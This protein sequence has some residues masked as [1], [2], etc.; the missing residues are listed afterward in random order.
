MTKWFGCFETQSVRIEQDFRVGGDYKIKINHSENI[1]V[2]MSGSFLEIVPNEKLV[3]SWNSD[4]VEYPAHNTLVTV[5]FFDK[6]A[7][8]EI[9]LK[10]SKFDRPVSVQGHS[11]GWGG[12]LDKFESLFA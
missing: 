11:M 3:Y 9:L 10:H 1:S 12:A 7:T 5:E 8:T 2:T 4:S 6:G